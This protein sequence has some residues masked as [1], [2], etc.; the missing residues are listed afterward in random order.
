MTALGLLM[1]AGRGGLNAVDVVAMSSS[2]YALHFV[3]V[4]IVVLLVVRV[5][6]WVGL[7]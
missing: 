4:V 5:G 6:V 2:T 3:C 7:L 1:A